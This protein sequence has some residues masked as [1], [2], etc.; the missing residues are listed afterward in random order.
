MGNSGEIVIDK[1][2][3]GG[4]LPRDEAV[5]AA[6]R[7]EIEAEVAAH[8]DLPLVRPVQ[9]LYDCIMDQPLYRMHLTQAINQAHAAGYRLGYSDIDGLMRR[10]NMVMH[11]APPFSTTELV[12]CPLNAL[13]DWPMCMPSG[14]AFFQFPEINAKF[15]DVLAYWSN[16][17]SGPHSRHYLTTENPKGWFSSNAAQKVDMSEYLCDP[18]L[19]HWGFGSW[20]DFFTRLFKPGQ[21]PVAAPNDPLVVNSACESTPYALQHEVRFSDHFWIKAQPYSLADMFTRDRHDLAAYFTGGT[22]YQAFLSAYNYHRWH[23]PVAGT[24]VDAYLVPGT[25]YADAPAEGLDPA[26]PNNSQGFLSAVATRAVMVIDTG[27]PVLGKVAC[28]FIGMAEISSCVFSVKIGQQLAKGDELGYFQYGGSTH[29]LIFGPEVQLNFL[30]PQPYSENDTQ[31]VK[32]NTAL[33]NV[34]V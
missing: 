27:H 6:F 3:L 22:V 31:V 12:G 9:A 2:R 23:A 30:P 10:I 29:C 5:L 7:F 19:P 14:F 28:I 25:Y 34:I 20:N 32:L 17:L 13:L 21:R 11:Y 16:F 1:E 24:V 4:W 18:A 33:A 26:G 8:P 15:R